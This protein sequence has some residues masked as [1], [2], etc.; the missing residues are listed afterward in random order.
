[1]FSRKG[2]IP[3]THA[4]FHVYVKDPLI[5]TEN[6]RGV[7]YSK[8]YFGTPPINYVSGTFLVS[9]AST[10]GWRRFTHLGQHTSRYTPTCSRAFVS[11]EHP[12]AGVIEP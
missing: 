1:M 12:T 5:K 6:D 7:G 2:P 9:R 4:G 8:N 10:E 11:R 3:T